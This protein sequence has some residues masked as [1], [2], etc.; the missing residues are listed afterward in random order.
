M[1]FD[2]AFD[3]LLN[4]EGIL[5]MDKNDS[6]NWTGGAVGIGTL[7]GSKY[8]ISAASYPE[9][10]IAAVTADRARFLFRRD[11]WDVIN[12]DKLADGVA[13]QLADFAYNSGAVQAIRYL[14][15]ALLVADD[16]KWGPHSQ[17]AADASSET[18]TI[19]LLCSERLEYM[20]RCAG[21]P[22]QGKGWTRRMA[23]NLRYAAVD[24]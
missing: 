3:R 12:A 22:A 18:D 2:I 4:H 20:T 24:S 13:W 5:S 21:W 17:A 15:R 6:G 10:D 23:G 1:N 19:F 8:G 9:E 11:F 7:K 16:G 14:Q